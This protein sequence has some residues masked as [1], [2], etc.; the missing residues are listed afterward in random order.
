MS[1]KNE[2]GTTIHVP[3]LLNPTAQTSCFETML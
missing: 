3:F 1:E 2:K